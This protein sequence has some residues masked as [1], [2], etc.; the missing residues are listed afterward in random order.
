MRLSRRCRDLFCQYQGSQPHP[1]SSPGASHPLQLMF[2]PHASDMR[3]H[4]ETQRA[5]E[6]EGGEAL[7]K[8]VEL[9]PAPYQS[10]PSGSAKIS[11]KT[12]F[13]TGGKIKWPTRTR[14]SH[15]CYQ[16]E[17]RLTRRS[18]ICPLFKQKPGG[19]S[20]RVFA[21]AVLII[22]MQRVAALTS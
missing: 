22:C 7:F 14:Q 1:S 8:F 2:P 12:F 6:W 21:E 15:K 17:G 13:F 11:L 9:V 19:S 3:Q 10:S 4:K 20:T 16:S 18:M 5:V